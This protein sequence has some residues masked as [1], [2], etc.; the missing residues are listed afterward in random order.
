MLTSDQLH[1]FLTVVRE[2]N[3]LAAARRLALDHSTVSRRLSALEAQLDTRLFDRS[4]RGLAPTPAGLALVIEAEKVESALL[5]AASSV[6]GIDNAVTGTVRLATPEIFGTFLIAPRVPE[7][8]ARHPG[9]SLELAPESRSISLSKREADIAIMLRQPPKG[10]LVARKLVDYRIG[11]YAGRGY[12]EQ[13]GPIDSPAQLAEHGFVSYIDEL[14]AFPELVVLD[15]IVPHARIVFQSSSSAAQQAAVAAGA[16][17]GMLHVVAAD[18]DPAL[19]RLLP[20]EIEVWRSYWLV[21]H[22][23]L[24]RVPRIRAVADFIDDAVRDRHALL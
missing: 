16:G 5:A 19:V 12:L 24:R 23:D 20:A 13:A 17:L 7:L 2:G 1:A 11:L 21:L 3:T 14:V 4:P 6:A 18:K 8:A 15:Q 9:L 10:R 22:A